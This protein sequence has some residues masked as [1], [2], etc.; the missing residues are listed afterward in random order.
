MRLGTPQIREISEDDNLN[1]DKITERKSEPLR[2]QLL[3]LR[4]QLT[5]IESRLAT[6]EAL[7]TD[8]GKW[9]E[10]EMLVAQE[11]GLRIEVENSLKVLA[12]KA[13]IVTKTL[14][15][16]EK[17]LQRAKTMPAIVRFVQGMTLTRIENALSSL[18]RQGDA[19]ADQDTQARAKLKGIV[20]N[21]DRL[22]GEARQIEGKLKQVSLSPIALEGEITSTRA[23]I[24]DLRT[25]IADLER[26]IEAI[27]Q[28]IINEAVLIATTLARTYT[29]AEVYGRQFDT[30]VCDEASMAPI[31]AL[32][33][34]CSRATKSVTVAGD[35]HQL[36]PIAL[37]K[38]VR[39]KEWLRRDVYAVAGMDKGWELEQ[40]G[41]S[42]MVMLITQYRMQPQ[43][44]AIISSVFYD[45]RLRDGI[46]EEPAIKLNQ[47]CPGVYVGVYDTAAIDPWCSWTSNYSRFNLYHAVLAVRLCQSAIRDFQAEDIG[48]ITPYKAQTRLIKVLV[49]MDSALRDKV[50]VSNVHRF[51]GR[52]SD[53]IILDLVDSTGLRVGKLLKGRIE[54]KDV[55]ESGGARLINVACS[56]AKKK[57]AIIA[58]L[59]FLK[60]RLDK[61]WSI[62]KVLFGEDDKSNLPIFPAEQLLP[63][64]SDP[65]VRQAQEALWPQETMTG[66]AS[67]LWTEDIF[68]SGLRRDL[69][70]SKRYA[71][72]MSPFI[73]RERLQTYI[74]LFRPKVEQGI[75]L[76]VITRP[77]YQQ[78][79]S[80]KNGIEKMLSYLAQIGIKV[81]PRP[82]MHQKV[83]VI[84]GQ[85][86]WFGS[87]N[88]LSHRNTQELMFRLENEDF[89]KQVMKE[90]GLHAPG[91]EGEGL[92]PAIDITKIPPRLCSSCGRNMKVIPRGRFGPFYK[93]EKCNSTANVRRDDL[94]QAIVPEARI[95]PKCGR[96]ME[97]RQSRTGV[98]LGCSGYNDKENQCRYTRPL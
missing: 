16:E 24:D 20:G 48:V 1:L 51:Q 56:R 4:D 59:S 28:Q 70:N 18:A 2:E 45:N 93:C 12:H 76:E 22:C 31:P 29:M 54:S 65:A 19:L 66:A 25:Q 92:V 37:S 47:P 13:S 63:G 96:E 36:A 33:W 57:L 40:T 52:E 49:D 60:P 87:L 61:N 27:R 11:E 62:Y 5:G 42:P 32:F 26:Q 98:F 9:E 21:L 85:V 30:V 77:P 6:L 17:R 95:C 72:I 41:Y 75:K 3:K 38:D 71:I 88:P 14:Q 83:I 68:H 53:L 78:G 34:A 55:D 39:V 46:L 86:V 15:K 50:T 64:Y 23:R 35:F 43:I 7:K 10:I 94:K 69:E 44:R 91:D 58:N 81:T 82:S 8:V 84:D 74:D 73:T 67:S 79:M 80:D 90:C 97:I 89:T